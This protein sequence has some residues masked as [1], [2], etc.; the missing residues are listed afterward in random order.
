MSVYGSGKTAAAA[1]ST[2]VQCEEALNRFRTHEVTDKRMK[3]LSGLL[4]YRFCL[5]PHYDV[6]ISL[7]LDS[8]NKKCVAVNKRERSSQLEADRSTVLSVGPCFERNA[9]V[10]EVMPE[11]FQCGVRNTLE[12]YLK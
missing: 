5:T 6:T 3:W 4:A 12:A 9:S 7:L 2:L 1:E 10:L 8:T 11:V